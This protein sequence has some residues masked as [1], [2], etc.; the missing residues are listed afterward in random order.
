ML[1]I[2]K[3]SSNSLF[4]GICMMGTPLNFSVIKQI[5]CYLTKKKTNNLITDMVMFSFSSLFT[6]YGINV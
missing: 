5:M 3:H 4:R 1:M 6:I 2:H